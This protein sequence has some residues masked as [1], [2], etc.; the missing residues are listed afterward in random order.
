MEKIFE[1]TKEEY[2]KMVADN[3]SLRRFC[4]KSSK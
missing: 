2:D 3:A 1:L 4:K